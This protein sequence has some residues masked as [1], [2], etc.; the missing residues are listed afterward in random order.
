MIRS[1]KTDATIPICEFILSKHDVPS[2]ENYLTVFNRECKLVSKKKIFE[3]ITCDYSFALL[4][5]ITKAFCSLDLV[6]YLEKQY[7][8]IYEKKGSDENVFFS[9]GIFKWSRIFAS[10]K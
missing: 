10:V 7:E 1:E 4:N 9:K 6:N 3:T 2:I 5:A 8:T